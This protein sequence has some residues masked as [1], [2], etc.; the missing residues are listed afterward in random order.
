[1]FCCSWGSFGQNTLLRAFLH[2]VAWSWWVVGWLVG[3]LA[4]WLV[5]WLIILLVGWLRPRSKP[6]TLWCGG[7]PMPRCCC[8]CVCVCVFFFSFLFVL[9]Q[10]GP[11]SVSNVSA[12]CTGAGEKD[13]DGQDDLSCRLGCIPPS[14]ALTKQK[15][16]QTFNA[17]EFVSFATRMQVRMGMPVIWHSVPAP[18]PLPPAQMHCPCCVQVTGFDD[19]AV[20]RCAR[21][22]PRVLPNC[23]PMH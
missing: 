22:W 14:T 1:V 10:V 5:D 17:D 13:A 9:V 7:A 19:C 11:E 12:F 2:A 8:Y 23:H 3:W 16:A 21:V 18:P 4:G 6:G 15:L 20:P